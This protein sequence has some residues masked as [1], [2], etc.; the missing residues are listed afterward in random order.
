[1]SSLNLTL[2]MMR[3]SGSLPKNPCAKIDKLKAVEETAREKRVK[4]ERSAKKQRSKAIQKLAKKVKQEIEEIDETYGKPGKP[5]KCSPAKKS[6]RK[7]KV[8]DSPELRRGT[9]MEQKEHGHGK[10]DARQIAADHL[11]KDPH[12]YDP[13]PRAKPAKKAAAKKATKKAGSKKAAKR[14]AKK[15]A[16]SKA[17]VATVQKAARAGQSAVEKFQ[18]RVIEA[19]QADVKKAKAE[20]KRE[21]KQA[22]KK[23]IDHEAKAA[24]KKAKAE[25]AAAKKAAKK[26][27]KAAAKQVA[28]AERPATTR[29]PK[30]KAKMP[31]QPKQPR[32]ARPDLPL[33][34]AREEV[35]VADVPAANDAVDASKD[36][37]AMA[38]FEAMIARQMADLQR[39]NTE[40]MP[41]R[42]YY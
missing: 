9:R 35:F 26:A 28:A 37:A 14:V 13:K 5:S 22:T 23:A 34:K 1:M 39:G 24:A 27:A 30:P 3:A 16:V 7:A 42:S 12:A 2:A 29:L 10:K 31:K 32:A 25:I 33:P 20:I 41:R 40:S 21:V 15:P 18:Q 17:K 19:T 4:V 38:G 6:S 11:A 36:A 8:A